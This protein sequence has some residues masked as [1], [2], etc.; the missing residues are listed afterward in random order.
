M[1]FRLWLQMLNTRRRA[2]RQVALNAGVNETSGLNFEVSDPSRGRDHPIALFRKARTRA[3]YSSG[4]ELMAPT[5]PP[6]GAIQS[7]LGSPAA[8]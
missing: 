1:S 5:C 6:L 4:Y 8:A 7:S 3:R 2:T